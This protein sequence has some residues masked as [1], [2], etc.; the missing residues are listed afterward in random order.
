M[1]LL[2]FRFVMFIL[3]T[4]ILSTQGGFSACLSAEELQY[5]GFV[6]SST[7][8]VSS[9]S[10]CKKTWLKYGRCVEEASLAVLFAKLKGEEIDRQISTFAG[11]VEAAV[12]NTDLIDL[13]VRKLDKLYLE[14]QQNVTG[15]RLASDFVEEKSIKFFSKLSQFF[16]EFLEKNKIDKSEGSDR[17]TNARLLQSNRSMQSSDQ[18]TTD[19]PQIGEIVS[20]VQGALNSTKIQM[21]HYAKN[22]VVDPSKMNFLLSK[23]AF[24]NQF[25]DS[26]FELISGSLCILTSK[27]AT[28]AIKRENSGQTISLLV[29]DDVVNQVLELNIQII[30]GFYQFM[31]VTEILRE[32]YTE[33]SCDADS[34]FPFL[35]DPCSDSSN[36]II[37]D[38]SNDIK[39][40]P[41]TLKNMLFTSFFSPLSSNVDSLVSVPKFI[42][43]VR[44]LNSDLFDKSSIENTVFTGDLD[45]NMNGTSNSTNLTL[46]FS[47]SN[48]GADIITEGANSQLAISNAL[49]GAQIP[50]ILL[51]MSAS[52][53][54]A[55]IAF[56]LLVI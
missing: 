44:K 5:L 37:E 10:I 7:D 41:Q 34:E 54:G 23:E 40:C 19:Q 47:I 38:C 18:N 1:F 49:V 51:L 2:G 9:D 55:T 53:F 27:N 25:S 22:V 8:D 3:I 29:S 30:K 4:L 16:K 13:V 39:K 12:S 45:E 6:P 15:R 24:R 31:K 21:V 50:S 36:I 11:M 32:G 52:V 17:K 14:S 56:L 28:K 46:R 33:A 35:K 42:N 43:A 48:D 26:V 20:R